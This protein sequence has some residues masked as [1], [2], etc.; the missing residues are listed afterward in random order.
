MNSFAYNIKT[1]SLWGWN[2][3]DRPRKNEKNSKLKYHIKT[4]VYVGTLA[5]VLDL[6]EQISK[7][8]ID[9][10]LKFETERSNEIKKI[11]EDLLGLQSDY[12][13]KRKRRK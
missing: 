8:K 12:D 9:D 11:K 4:Q 6:M 7:N 3:A 13:I 1:E 2:I 10:L 5:T